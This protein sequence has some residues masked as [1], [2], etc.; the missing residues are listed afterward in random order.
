MRANLL[1]VSTYIFFAALVAACGLSGGSTKPTIVIQSPADGSQLREGDL[2]PIQS[3]A[4]D[5]SG[6]VSI[7]LTVDGVTARTDKPQSTPDHALYSLTQT[8]KATAGK[9]TLGV[10]AFNPSGAASD[11]VT[12]AVTVSASEAVVPTIPPVA[13]LLPT[14]SVDIAGEWDSEFGKV[15]L[16]MGQTSGNGQIPLT[17]YW[18]QSNEN[19]GTIKSGAFDPQIGV[20]QISYYEPWNSM[21]GT[22]SFSL[23]SDARTLKGTWKQSNGQGDWTL[24]RSN[25]AAAVLNPPTSR[26]T[27]TNTPLP[28]SKPIPTATLT[29]TPTQMA[30]PITQLIT[31][32][33][34]DFA[35]KPDV[36]AWGNTQYAVPP[37]G[38]TV[39][40][41]CG[42][43]GCWRLQGWLA[44]MGTDGSLTA[45]CS[46][47]TTDLGV[48]I[49]GDQDDG[50][51]RI[52]VDGVE[53]W[54]GNTRGAS[55]DSMPQATIGL[56]R[57][58]TMSGP[59]IGTMVS[60]PAANT[61]ASPRISIPRIVQGS[62]DGRSSTT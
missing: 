36:V 20:L 50:I 47:P 11:L 27:S 39:V 62:T 53:M 22:A 21:E 8:W 15:T 45:T 59:F 42:N 57:M 25:P 5:P 60:P 30:A 33:A 28:T 48:Q 49:W 35:D 3:A 32:N 40:E 2:V 23:S 14:P 4:N 58:R 9:H 61:S 7:D 10:R 37:S 24:T 56:G 17:G 29:A 54:R 51:G 38:V 52:L 41:N 1:R 26:P 55:L 13:T 18:I 16:Q 12:I 46:P 43:S 44:L 6:I 19:K 31:G 34:R